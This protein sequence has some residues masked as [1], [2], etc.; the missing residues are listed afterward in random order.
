[1]NLPVSTPG[2]SCVIIGH[3]LSP[4]HK[5]WGAEIDKHVVV[6]MKDPSWQGKVDYGERLDYLCASTET[7]PAML[8]C[9]RMPLEYWAQPKKGEWSKAVEAQFR[10][11]AKAPLLIGEHI[12]AHWNAVFKQIQAE[13]GREE[14]RNHS[15]GMFAITMAARQLG[16][17][18]IRLVGFDN[19]LNPMLMDYYKANRGK[20]VTRHDWLAERAMLPL[21]EKD[22]GVEIRAWV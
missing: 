2:K 21:V 18:Q 17:A 20:W 4:L 9:K 14:V 22:Y 15:L 16:P 10:G 12:F 8:D 6:R 3:G 13:L 7:M 1:M 19:L 5:G 11:R